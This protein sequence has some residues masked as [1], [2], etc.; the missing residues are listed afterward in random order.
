MAADPTQVLTYLTQA[1]ANMAQNIQNLTANPKPNYVVDSK[2]YS[3][4]DLLKQYTD[5][6]QELDEAISRAEGPFEDV[7]TGYT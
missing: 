4:G 2:S 1:R 5:S 7:I 6:L 3:F